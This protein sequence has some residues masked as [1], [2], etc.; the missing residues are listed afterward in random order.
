MHFMVKI[1]ILVLVLGATF[2]FTKLVL[3]TSAAQELD[4]EYKSKK[5]SPV[6]YINPDS[7]FYKSPSQEGLRPVSR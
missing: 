4:V 6:E 1:S 2:A 5:Y 7:P 3:S